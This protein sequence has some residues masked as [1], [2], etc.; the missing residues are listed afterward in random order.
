MGEPDPERLAP[1]GKP[2]QT[3]D[4]GHSVSAVTVDIIRTP[5]YLSRNFASRS[6]A[7]AT[8]R[9]VR[10]AA[11][12]QAQSWS[13]R[14]TS[15]TDIRKGHSYGQLWRHCPQTVRICKR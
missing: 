1:A 11:G 9:I 2:S 3:P 8:G 14:V 15:G 6:F 5:S 13:R 4:C 12:R 10:G 7:G